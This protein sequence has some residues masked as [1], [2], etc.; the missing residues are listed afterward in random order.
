MSKN[1]TRERICQA[2]TE[3]FAKHGYNKTSMDEIAKKALLGK[4]TIYYHF[5]SKEDLFI[6]AV[7]QKA[8]E[9]FQALDSCIKDTSS[10]EKKLS[11][12][13]MLPM[14]YIFE[15]MPLLAEAL[16][17][18]SPQYITRLQEER[19]IYHNKMTSILE[20]IIAEG[21]EQGIVNQD[22]DAGRLSEVINDWFLLGDTWV[23]STEKDKIIQRMERDHEMI[24]DLILNGIL[25]KTTPKQTGTGRNK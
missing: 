14:K 19:T 18:L 3:L 11:C 4:A 16:N 12:Y 7:W 9:L 15:H 2:A 5:P 25:K 10:F 17:Q 6:E 20:A 1:V 24:I 21:K 23:D 8:D 13:L 22:I